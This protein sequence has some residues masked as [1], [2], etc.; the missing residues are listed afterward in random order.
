MTLP[1]TRGEFLAASH[2]KCDKEFRVESSE[3]VS[4]AWI[5]FYLKNL[6]M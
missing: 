4:S 3:Y 2:R 5:N 6:C 1:E